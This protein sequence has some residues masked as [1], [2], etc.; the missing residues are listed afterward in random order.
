M[1]GYVQ[2]RRS[3]VDVEMMIGGFDDRA[4]P[5]SVAN[6]GLSERDVMVGPEEE[7]LS[8]GEENPEEMDTSASFAYSVK[9]RLEDIA[10]RR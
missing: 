7:V 2:G 1:V 8:V 10:R 5:V 6:V 3:S 4:M 9:R